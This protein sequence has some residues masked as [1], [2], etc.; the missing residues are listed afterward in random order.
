MHGIVVLN[1]PVG[2]TSHDCVIKLRRLFDT[3]KVG[4][5]GTLDPDVSGVLPICIGEATKIVPYLTDTLKTYQAEITLGFSTDTE[6]KSGVEIDRLAVSSPLSEADILEALNTFKGQIK[7]LTPMYSAVKVNGKKLYE[8]ARENKP[9][10]RPVRQVTIHDL[11][12]IP[13]SITQ[14][15]SLFSFGFEATVSKGTYI[16]TLCVDIG[17]K[18]GYPAHM[19]GLIRT[20]TA[21]FSLDDAVTLE[22]LSALKT[23]NQLSSILLPLKAGL[24]HLPVYEVDEQ[25]KQRVLF[26]QKLKRPDFFEIDR[27]Y[28]V[29]YKGQ[30]LAI[31]Q[32]HPEDSSII[33]SSRGFNL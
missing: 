23:N 25:T 33:K 26:G 27:P 4:H 8:Y 3:K 12:F 13:G 7:Q 18:L 28:R 19:S 11:S 9:V 29:E 16:R 5:T 2:Y 14:D 17:K 15:A 1:K 31:Y 24:T 20:K 32:S 30:L 6:D 22:E 21:D 10:E